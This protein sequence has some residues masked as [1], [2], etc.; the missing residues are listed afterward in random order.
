MNSQAQSSRS[1]E[2]GEGPKPV[3]RDVGLA[4]EGDAVCA[5]KKSRSS[6]TIK[7]PA[8]RMFGVELCAGT[9]IL[10]QCISEIGL[11]PM[12]VDHSYNWHKPKVACVKLDLSVASGWK[13]LYDLLAESRVAFVHGAPPCGTA[14][15]AREKKIPLRLKGKGCPEPKRLRSDDFPDTQG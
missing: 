7:V 9:A 1:F 10:S 15:R 11:Q 12:A 6:E 13:I 3:L 2:G 4:E 8:A 5:S 14:S